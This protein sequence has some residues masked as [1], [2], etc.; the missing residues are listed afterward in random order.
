MKLWSELPEDRSQPG[1]I[2][3]VV[4]GGKIALG[5]VP[6][7][8]EA[9]NS[10]AKKA[11]NETEDPTRPFGDHPWGL[12]RVMGVRDKPE[13]ARSYGP[14]FLPLDPVHG[15]ALAAEES[16]RTG[17]GIHGGDPAADGS[18]RVTH[19][20]LRLRNADAAKL[21]A[22]VQRKLKTPNATV[23]YECRPL[24][25]SPLREFTQWED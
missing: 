6:A 20:C 10:A 11:G 16:G 25:H 17:L 19:G 23:F 24:G 15:E 7:F 5:P 3:Y 12:Y 13:P 21:A 18:L 1:G 2:F 22:L 4:E 8:G 9:D 14:A